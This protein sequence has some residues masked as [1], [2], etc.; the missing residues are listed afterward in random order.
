MPEPSISELAEHLVVSYGDV[1]GEVHATT[2]SRW[3]L[4][5]AR[6]QPDPVKVSVDLEGLERCLAR[7]IEDDVQGA[8]PEVDATTAA[9]RL[10]SVHL[11]EEIDSANAQVYEVGLDRQG[12]T[13]R[14]AGE[15]IDPFAGLPP[16][17]HGWST[18][19]RPEQTPPPS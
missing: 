17:G 1:V 14:R 3:A 8:F 13:W 9:W 11:C 12:R 18:G 6:S 7:A 10:A 19:T 16:G 15:P 5:R 2:E 4:V